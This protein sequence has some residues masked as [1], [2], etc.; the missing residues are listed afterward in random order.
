MV[1]AGSWSEEYLDDVHLVLKTFVTRGF[2]HIPQMPKTPRLRRALRRVAEL[3]DKLL[4]ERQLRR[5]GRA[6]NAIDDM[7]EL[8]RA[9]P[10]VPPGVRPA[11]HR[12]VSAVRRPG[13]RH[14]RR[15]PPCSTP[16]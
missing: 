16:C 2:L 11:D 13:D 10:D 12:P 9:D 6:T 4:L 8:H 1:V 7:L 14:Q 15:R 3:S 5:R